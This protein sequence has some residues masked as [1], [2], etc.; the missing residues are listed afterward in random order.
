MG[1]S[2]KQRQQWIDLTR[3]EAVQKLRELADHV[4]QDTLRFA[5]EPMPLTTLK[6][7]KVALT[8]EG[9]SFTVV[10]KLK[11]H[12][13]HVH[14]DHRVSDTPDAPPNLTASRR[15]TTP[16]PAG[17]LAWKPLKRAMKQHYRTLYVDFRQGRLPDVEAVRWLRDASAHQQE[18]RGHEDPAFARFSEISQE[19][20]Q[21]VEQSAQDRAVALW[22]ELCTQHRACHRRRR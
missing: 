7:V 11:A 16:A 20:L 10:Q 19:L 6:R 1:S 21:A 4:E 3:A 18:M 2:R 8:P 17:T 9:D 5:G 12:R 13:S 22:Q 15:A 14:G